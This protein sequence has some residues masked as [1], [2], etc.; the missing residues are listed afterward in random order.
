PILLYLERDDSDDSNVGPLYARWGTETPSFLGERGNLKMSW[1]SSSG[2]Q[3]PVV[4]WSDDRG[5]LKY[6][7]VGKDLETVAKGVV[8]V[9]SVGVISEYDGQNGMFSRLSG[10][11]LTEVYDQVHANGMRSDPDTERVLL[12]ADIED[13]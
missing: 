8:H 2:T 6:G 10:A 9:S 4:D 13:G 7:S 5:T 3:R 1:I 11:N 12:V